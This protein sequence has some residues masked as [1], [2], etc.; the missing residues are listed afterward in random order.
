[1]KKN[2]PRCVILGG[3]GH[4]RVVLESLLSSQVAIPYA[5]LDANANLWGQTLFKVPIRGSDEKLAEILREG[6]TTFV[7]G[8]GTTGSGAFRK[9]LF[10]KA[11]KIGLK[12]LTIIHPNSIVSQWAKLGEGCQL[13][14]GCVVN[15]GAVLG[16]NVIVNTGAIVEHDCQLGDHVHVATGARLASTVIVGPQAHIGVGASIRE[17][18]TIGSKAIVGAGAVVVNSVKAG[19]T[20][21]GIP[22][23]PLRKQ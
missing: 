3:G 5:I 20:V 15:A 7:V 8:L 13:L 22:A 1:M 16:K 10:E 21:T 14:P 4:A 23:R 18:L 17:C 2:K 19:T 11:L 6:V 9:N 12:P